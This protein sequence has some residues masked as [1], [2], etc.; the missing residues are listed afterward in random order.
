MFLIKS[1]IYEKEKSFLNKAL[2][3][4]LTTTFLQ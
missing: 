3:V 2:T 1:N 4:I